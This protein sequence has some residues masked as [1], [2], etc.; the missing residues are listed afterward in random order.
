MNSQPGLL[1]VKLKSNFVDKLARKQLTILY[2]LIKEVSLINVGDPRS[3]KI[4]KRLPLLHHKV[5]KSGILE[6]D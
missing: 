1:G 5:S 3:T 2:R 4:Y 6:M